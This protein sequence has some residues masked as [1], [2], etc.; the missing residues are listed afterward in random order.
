M[1]SKK[2][3]PLH[4]TKT[5]PTLVIDS[6]HNHTLSYWILTGALKEAPPPYVQLRLIRLWLQ[7]TDRELRFLQ[8][9]TALG[10]PLT[11]NPHPTPRQTGVW[12]DHLPV[13]GEKASRPRRPKLPERGGSPKCPTRIQMSKAIGDLSDL[14]R[15]VFC[16]AQAWNCPYLTPSKRNTIRPYISLST[17]SAYLGG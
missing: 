6:G 11:Q 7:D 12:Y 2:L 16:R 17:V 8:C 5:D 15:I 14:D 10:Q 9:P 3:H 13:R 4:L 1:P